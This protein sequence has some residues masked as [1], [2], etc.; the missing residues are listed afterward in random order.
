MARRGSDTSTAIGLI[1]G[2]GGLLMGFLLEGGNPMGLVGVSALIIIVL[3]TLGACTISYSLK[4]VLGIPRL[5]RQ[6]LVRVPGPSPQLAQ[7]LLEFA[8]KARRDGILSLEDTVEDLEDETLR[9]GLRLV[10]DGTE[11][12]ILVEVLESDLSILE[13]RKMEEA[14]LFETAGGFSPTMGIIGTVMG[15]VLVLGRL[16]ADTKELG[17]S[18]AVAFIAT[19]YGISFANLIWLPIANKLKNQVKQFRLEKQLIIVGVRSIQQGESPALVKEKIEG[20]LEERD[21][22]A[23]DE[24]RPD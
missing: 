11:S 14:A 18:I 7:Q 15:L 20:F 12:E 16:G 5:I 8:E 1:M 3:G 22:K 23:L 10:V 24:T 4:D 21:K 19:L 2:F 17:R 13:Q 9:K 6:S